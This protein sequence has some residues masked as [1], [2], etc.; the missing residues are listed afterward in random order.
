MF[1]SLKMKKYSLLTF[2]EIW[3]RERDYTIS[4]KELIEANECISFNVIF[5]QPL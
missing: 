1:L 3:V 2:N 5:H 4:K